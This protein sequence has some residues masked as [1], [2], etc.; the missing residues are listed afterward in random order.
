MPLKS[1]CW[2]RGNHHLEVVFFVAQI[3][4][5]RRS[6]GIVTGSL[7]TIVRGSYFGHSSPVGRVLLQN[8][9]PGC[10]N[11]SNVI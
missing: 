4:L 9:K 10:P 2:C 8:K 3:F 1:T 7:T 11:S 5:L 6:R